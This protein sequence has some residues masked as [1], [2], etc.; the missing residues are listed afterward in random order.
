MTGL[1]FHNE[2]TIL[3][4]PTIS[5][6]LQQT[7]HHLSFQLTY[8]FGSNLIVLN[9]IEYHAFEIISTALIQI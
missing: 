7:M 8:R 9:N 2:P 1:M 5:F 3:I 6:A 4:G